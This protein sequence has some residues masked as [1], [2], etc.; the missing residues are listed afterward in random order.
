VTEPSLTPSSVHPWVSEGYG[1]LRFG[2]SIFPHPLDWQ[3]FIRIGQR[4]EEFGMDGYFAFDHPMDRGDSWTALT[5]LA[6]ATTK[7]RLGTSVSCIYYR[8]PYMLARLAADVDRL[9]G[10]RVIVGLGIGDKIEEFAQMGIPFPDAPMRLRNME[11]TLEILIR[12]WSGEKFSYRGHFHHL[13]DAQLVAGPVQE[14]LPILLAGGGEKVTLRQVAQYADASNFGSHAWIGSAFSPT[15]Y[16]RKFDILGGHLE[17]FG[18]P[19]DALVRSHFTM[20]LI[21][22]P[23]REA[24][25]AKLAKLPADQVEWF[26]SAMLAG[27][28]DDA[29]AYYKNLAAL[30]MNYFIV[31]ILDQDWES[32]ELLGTEVMPALT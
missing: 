27:T 13:I 23:T 32:F 4:C 2:I 24:A 6:M 17:A 29:I 28:P 9:S 3:E 19:S 20:P 31:N 26:R 25:E 22:A 14:R 8:N 10:G 5:A 15:D 11:E 12:L 16:Q 30:G 18:R 21:I 7:L 1:K